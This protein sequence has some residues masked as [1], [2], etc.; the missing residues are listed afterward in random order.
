MGNLLKKLLK[1][2]IFAV[3]SHTCS[4]ASKSWNSTGKR[5]CLNDS[6]SKIYF[7]LLE[8]HYWKM[9]PTNLSICKLNSEPV[10]FG[11]LLCT[12]IVKNI[13]KWG[14]VSAQAHKSHFTSSNCCHVKLGS[15]L[16]LW[17][18]CRHK[19]QLIMTFTHFWYLIDH[20]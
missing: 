4:M 17:H 19:N 20:R 8:I 18:Q 7:S 3:R 11:T 15:G 5:L 1:I 12:I 10:S 9:H 2:Y 14:F 16:Y 6:R 13:L